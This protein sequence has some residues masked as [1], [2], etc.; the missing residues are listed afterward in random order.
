MTTEEIK[1][2][3]LRIK[4][5]LKEK[6]NIS[7][8]KDVNKHELLELIEN[9]EN[10]IEKNFKEKEKLQEL[11]EENQKVYYRAD[12]KG[13]IIAVSS[14]IETLLGYKPEE[15]QGVEIDD[16]LYKYP[17]ERLHLFQELQEKGEVNNFQVTLLHKSGYSVTV[18][19][20]SYFIYDG[21]GN[22]IGIEG[23]F[24][25]ITKKKE[26]QAKVQRED[27]KRKYRTLTDQLPVGIYRTTPDG[28][29]IYF[30]TMRRYCSEENDT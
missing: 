28:K 16:K 1:K 15:L 12:T 26:K 11:P 13:S 21:K 5:L 22:P 17:D 30:N 8:S 3:I 19:T 2:H 18:S 27:K 23:N 7:E 24:T 6:T 29:F 14:P 25:D 20:N 9:L 10:Q 4:T